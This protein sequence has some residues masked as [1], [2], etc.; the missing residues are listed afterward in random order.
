MGR[1]RHFLDSLDSD[2]GH[3]FVLLVLIAA[4]GT[5]T[6][7]GHMDGSSIVAGAFGALLLALKNAGSNLE[8]LNPPTTKV[9]ATIT[10]EIA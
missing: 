8:Q 6:H 5:L 1:W 3:I 2:G 7:L 10:K 4:G 9:S